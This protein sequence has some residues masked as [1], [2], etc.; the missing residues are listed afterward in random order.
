MLV[1]ITNT[2]HSSPLWYINLIL[3]LLLM[4]EVEIDV[5]GGSLHMLNFFTQ[6]NLS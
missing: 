1:A 6:N 4:P 3:F 5:F 2:L